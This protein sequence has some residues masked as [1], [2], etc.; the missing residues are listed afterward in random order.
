[1]KSVEIHPTALLDKSVELDSGVVIGPYSIIKGKVRIGSG[2]RIESH[3]VIGSEFGQVTMGR[4]NKI[5][6]G[7]M[8]GG[9]PQDLKYANEPTRLEIGDGNQIRE[10]VT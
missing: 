10:F 9:P 8:V 1:M 4:D 5:F 6:S 2:T 7:A 3:V